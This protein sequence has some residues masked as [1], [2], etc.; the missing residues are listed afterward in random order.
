MNF[1]F[2]LALVAVV[3]YAVYR[4]VNRVDRSNPTNS[5]GSPKPPRRT[6]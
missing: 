3:G 4:F 1:V 5:G 6:Q 2:G